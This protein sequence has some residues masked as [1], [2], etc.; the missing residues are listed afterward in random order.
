MGV[1]CGWVLKMED[2]PGVG[3]SMLE[4]DCGWVK[5]VVSFPSVLFP[6]MLGVPELPNKPVG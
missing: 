3:W 2:W 1:G 4:V 6:K 5:K